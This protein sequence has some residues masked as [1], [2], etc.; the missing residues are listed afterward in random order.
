[1]FGSSVLVK[2]NLPLRR[3]SFD[4]YLAGCYVS[5]VAAFSLFMNI[6]AAAGAHLFL[7]LFSVFSEPFFGYSVMAETYYNPNIYEVIFC[8]LEWARACKISP[9]SFHNPKFDD[10]QANHQMVM[11][12]LLSYMESRIPEIFIHSLNQLNFLKNF[13]YN[14]GYFITFKKK[15][16]KFR[17]YQFRVS[18]FQFFF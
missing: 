16:S 17:K 12:W 9:S 5:L 18:F 15:Y 13:T 7:Q 10:R 6:L 14:F 2:S 8:S 4:R 3:K 1:M 11:S